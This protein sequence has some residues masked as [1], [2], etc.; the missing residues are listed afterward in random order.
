M[1][2]PKNAKVRL[3]MI[4]YGVSQ[5]ALGRR[6]GVNQAQISGMLTRELIKSEQEDL[7]A[8]IKEIG[9]SK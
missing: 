3:A 9:E 6:L 8:T 4:E 7:I 1:A 2:T 5:R